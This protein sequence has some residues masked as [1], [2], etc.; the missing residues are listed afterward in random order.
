[1][2]RKGP[3]LPSDS[4]RLHPDDRIE[5]LGGVPTHD[6]GHSNRLPPHAGSPPTSRFSA[7]FRHTIGATPTDYRRTLGRRLHRGSRR[8]SDTRL[9]PLQPTTAARWHEAARSQ[10]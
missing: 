7:A 1:M 4:K 10:E 8:R 5:V 9:G 6:W 3:R 2:V